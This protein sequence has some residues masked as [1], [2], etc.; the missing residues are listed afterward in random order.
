MKKIIK[1][2]AVGLGAVS[3]VPFAVGACTTYAHA[4]DIGSDF[5]TDTR[6]SAVGLASIDVL[7]G[8]LGDIANEVIPDSSLEDIA[9][10]AINLFAEKSC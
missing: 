7:V 10:S 6:Y 8:V 5:L 2:L 4:E 3:F 9:S 1:A